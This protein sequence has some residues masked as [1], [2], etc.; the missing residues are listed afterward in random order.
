MIRLIWLFI[1]SILLVSCDYF[2]KEQPKDPVARVNNSYLYKEDIASLIQE[3]TTPADSAIIV[4]NYINRWATQQLLIDKANVNLPIEQLA[5]Y[6]Q[7][8]SDYRN[9]L[10]TK[11]YKNAIV[12]RQLDITISELDY[13]EYYDQNKENFVLNDRLLQLRYIYISSENNN[14]IQIK[15]ALRRFNL[16]DKAKLEEIAIQF[17][18]YYGDDST[19]VKQESVIEKIPPLT[20]SNNIQLLKNSNYL[21][22]QDSI[23]VYLVQIKKV[24]KR[25]EIAPLVFVKPTIEQIILNKRKLDLIKKLE[26]DITKDAIRKND[27][28]VYQ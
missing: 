15:Q 12:S 23:G 25:N 24:L 27:F 19:W 9:D 5:N 13:Q 2:K 1:I 6:D 4:N 14:L 26:A 10:Y 17:I 21:Q 11:G 7:L 28:E 16:E 22:L 20:Q 8:V 18:R 3:N